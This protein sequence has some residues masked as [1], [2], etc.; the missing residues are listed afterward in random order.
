MTTLPLTYLKRPAQPAAG[1]PAWLL[2]LMHGVGSHA[3]DLFGQWIADCC[4]VGKGKFEKPTPLYNS[5]CSYAREAGEEP[6]AM[7]SFTES[8]Q[9]RGFPSKRTNA[10]R[11]YQGISLPPPPPPRS[12]G[13]DAW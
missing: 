13:S 1:Q 9:K 10:A 11:S 6:G 2:V 5:W 3:Q 4:I 7:K 12:D 8:L